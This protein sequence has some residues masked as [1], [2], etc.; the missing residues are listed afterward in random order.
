M[1]D[2]SGRIF[3]GNSQGSK[4][5]ELNNNEQVVISTPTI[6]AWTVS[7]QSK[8]LSESLAQNYSLVITT[9]GLVVRVTIFK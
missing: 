7:V 9:I 5:D 6:G 2:P 3:Y 4:R 8:L 1:T